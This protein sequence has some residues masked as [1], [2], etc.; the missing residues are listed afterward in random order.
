MIKN[1]ENYLLL[2]DESIESLE[3]VPISKEIAQYFD[4]KIHIV[5]E[6]HSEKSKRRKVL[7]NTNAIKHYIEDYCTLSRE[8]ILNIEGSRV[9][10]ILE[11]SLS[12]SADIIACTYDSDRFFGK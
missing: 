6:K 2:F 5:S 1:I 3:C 9:N 7:A 11:Y 12:I 10:T 8:K 4:A